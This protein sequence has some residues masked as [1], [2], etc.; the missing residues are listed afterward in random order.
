MNVCNREPMCAMGNVFAINCVEL[1]AKLMFD[2]H[3]Q[4]SCKLICVLMFQH[5]YAATLVYMYKY[6]RR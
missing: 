1:M 5:M 3:R 6:T 2:A 4:L